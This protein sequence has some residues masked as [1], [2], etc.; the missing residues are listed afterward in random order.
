MIEEKYFEEKFG[1]LNDKLDTVI[2]Q[3]K[4]TNGTVK[5]NQTRIDLLEKDDIRHYANC[6][7]T[8]MLDQIKDD[9]LEYRF[10]KKYPRIFLIGA[11][12]FFVG[13]VLVFLAQHGI[14]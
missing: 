1:R 10:V 4:K 2:D 13:S 8:K 12:L 6:P 9:L 14:I 3:V 7:N 11:G 5:E